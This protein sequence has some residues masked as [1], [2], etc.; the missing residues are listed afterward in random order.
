MY[1]VHRKRCALKR[2]QD[3]SLPK[4]VLTIQSHTPVTV[5]RSANST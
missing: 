5:W 2:T 3:A 1:D 4:Y